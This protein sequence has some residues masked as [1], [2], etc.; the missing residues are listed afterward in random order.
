VTALGYTVEGV[1]VTPAGNLCYLLVMDDLS[2]RS[3][4]IPR[5]RAADGPREATIAHALA[6]VYRPTKPL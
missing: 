4:T 6:N 2:R 5:K 3:V 1:R